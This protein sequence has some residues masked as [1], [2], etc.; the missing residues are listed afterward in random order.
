MEPS[1]PVEEGRQEQ[2]VPNMAEVPSNNGPVV[3]E[4]ILS[5]PAREASP[6]APE[7]VTRPLLGRTQTGAQEM[8]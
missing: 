4:A 7:L 1:L 5:E 2:G 8:L 6:L 3:W